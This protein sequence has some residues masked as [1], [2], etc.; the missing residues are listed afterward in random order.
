MDFNKEFEKYLPIWSEQKHLPIP[1][2]NHPDKWNEAWVDFLSEY[3]VDKYDEINNEYKNMALK[4]FETYNEPINPITPPPEPEIEEK[5]V[6][7]SNWELVQ[8]K[9]QKKWLIKFTEIKEKVNKI[10]IIGGGAVGFGL[11][12][13]LEKTSMKLKLIENDYDRCEYLSSILQKTLVLNASGTDLELLQEEEFGKNDV[14][15]AITNNDE[16]NL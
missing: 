4:G 3:L 14:V 6:K 12:Q 10:G 16:K 13:A 7:K 9:R 8:E 11:A 5:P 1:T 2:K 15:V